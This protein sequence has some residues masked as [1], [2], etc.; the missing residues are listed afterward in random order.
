[1]LHHDQK[2]AVR[3]LSPQA[4]RQQLSAK[5]LRTDQLDAEDCALYAASPLPEPTLKSLTAKGIQVQTQSWVPPVP[6]H[7]PL[8]FYLA[9]VPYAQ[10]KTLEAEAQV[11]RTVST[12]Q[13]SHP[14]NSLGRQAMHVDEVYSGSGVTQRTGRN[15]KVAIA[16]S[17]L[18]VTHADIPTPVERYDMTD[19]DTTETWGSDVSNRVTDHGTHVTGSLLGRGAWAGG[20]FA[21][22]AK[23][24][25][26]YF[27]KIGSD[28]D[29]TAASTDIIEAINRAKQVGCKIFSMSYGGFTDPYM[30]G[31]FPIAQAIDA[32]VAAG[33]TVFISAGNYRNDATHASMLMAPNSSSPIFTYRI[34]NSAGIANYRGAELI[35]V[36]WR[37]GQPGD[38]NL[39]LTCQGLAADE[40]LALA[41]T[42]VSSRNTEGR[43]YVLNCNVP[44]GRSVNYQLRL[45]N[46]AVAG[47]TPRVHCYQAG[48]VG[49]FT[50]PDPNYTMGACALADFAIAVGAWTQA[51]EWRNFLGNDYALPDETV[52]EIASYSSF[53]PRIDGLQKPDLLA[54]GGVT[55][56]CRDGDIALS[57][58]YIVDDNGL[59]LDGSG[60]ANYAAMWGTSMA[61][62]LAAGTAA[63]LLEND[64]TMTPARIRTALTGTAEHAADPDNQHGYGLIDAK[65]ALITGG[66]V[67]IDVQPAGGLN[68]G[69]QAL[70]AGPTATQPLVI[71]NLKEGK[72][73]IA[74]V[75]I[76]GTDAAQF[77]F[78]QAPA[79]T[80]IEWLESRILQIRFD[81]AS[82]GA[83]SARVEIASN[84]EDEPLRMIPLTGTGVTAPR[85]T[86]TR[87]DGSL[88]AN[89]ASTLQL[90]SAFVGSAS[91]TV[92]FRVGNSGSANLIVASCSA[93]APFSLVNNLAASIAPGVLDVVTVGL[94]TAFA[95]NYSGTILIQ[96]N[97]AAQSPYEIF[98]SGDVDGGP[99]LT[100]EPAWTAGTTNDLY[101]TE[102]GGA[103]EY[104]IQCAST[105]T[106][107]TIL[108]SA[109]LVAPEN[110]YIFSGL[111][112]GTH[113]Y[114]RVRA[115]SAGG[116]YSAW[117]AAANSTQDD[118]PPTGNFFINQAGDTYTNQLSVKL[119]P[120]AADAGSGPYAW[121][122][123]NANQVWTN[124]DDAAVTATL[125]LPAGDGTK[126][127]QAQFLDLAGNVSSSFA[128]AAIILD[129]TLPSSEVI[130]TDSVAVQARFPLQWTHGDGLKGSGV[131]S[132]AVYF[133]KSKGATQLLGTYPAKVTAVE[134]DARAHGGLGTYEFFS[135]ATDYAGNVEKYSSIDAMVKVIALQNG[136]TGWSLYQ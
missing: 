128:S 91:P 8:G 38:G 33:V 19:G 42:G 130:T 63:L 9:R 48:G 28:A 74:R 77:S 118:Q 68:F 113:Y 52:A 108:K 123:R 89:G 131:K 136:A 45:T 96:T 2:E 26:L 12:E 106:F 71:S 94:D 34:D 17:G 60:P 58:M 75:E 14:V 18:D 40:S 107:S 72:L 87:L 62:P 21:G 124:W 20:K 134:F 100:S 83:K 125:L 114:Y 119:T 69:N 57:S 115:R 10:L 110:Y 5:G 81:P 11:L 127:V 102:V 41:S 32:A 31:S 132:V 65:E 88:L 104:T 54:P 93:N 64:P 44:A 24:A 129:Q 90:G 84:D 50:A 112:H 37:D 95:G 86:V 109:T 3:L 70:H 133:R 66:P 120:T 27:Y 30:D 98:I 1:M 111:N 29:G 67:E 56:S 36:L 101:W 92:S 13:V 78:E 46:S 105:S 39:T 103:A 6:G 49:V 126:T 4:R 22:T 23:G 85:M 122:F 61:C 53:G 76:K 116:S 7:H 25:R 16:D 51:A 79:F 117:S 59:N 35:R 82:V 43:A 121:H 15:V 73:A 135:R 55:I 97:D 99:T 80:S 47:Q